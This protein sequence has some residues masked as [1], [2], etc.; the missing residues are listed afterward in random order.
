MSNS[1]LAGGHDQELT[2]RKFVRVFLQHGIE[3]VDFG[4][5]GG[6]GKSKEN[7]TRVKKALVEDQFAEIPVGNEQNAFLV[8]SDGK[9]IFISK[10]M[11]VLARD[12]RNV[13]AEL[14]NMSNQPK[15]GAL[16][17]EEFHTGVA[18]DRA[19]FG[20]FGETSSPATIAFA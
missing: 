10:T 5:K 8:P 19:P 14:T 17:E 2:A 4:L 11:G 9:D 13:M 1:D 18:S 3:V 12:G 16:V 15:I 20:G 6:S 7:D